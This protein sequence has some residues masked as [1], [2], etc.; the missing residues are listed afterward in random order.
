MTRSSW[1]TMLMLV[2]AGCGGT[3][4]SFKE[5]QGTIEVS[6]GLSDL[7]TLVIG[8]TVD[9]EIQVDNVEGADVNVLRVDVSNLDG[10]FFEVIQGEATVPQEGSATLTLRYTPLEAGY[11]YAVATVISDAVDPSIEVELRGIGA[12]AAPVLWPLAVDFGPVAVG[13]SSRRT[14]SISNDGDAPFSVTSA[15]IVDAQFTLD[16]ALPV[17][18]EAG[19]IAVLDVLFTPSTDAAAMTSMQL[20]LDVPGVLPAVTLVGN[21][22]ENGDPTAYDVDTDGFTTCGGDCD[23]SDPGVHPGAL[24][25]ADAADQDCD[26]AVD[27]G[28]SASDDDGDG[29]TEDDGDCNDDD[30]TVAPGAVEVPG[31]G[32]D[33]DCDGVVD[34]GSTDGDGDGVSVLGGDCDDADISVFPGAPELVDGKD[35]DCDGRTDEG[36]DAFDDDGDGYS[37]ATGDCDDSFASSFPGAPELADYRDN[38]CDTTVDEGTVLYDDDRDGFTENGG[39]CD[40][41][42]PLINPGAIESVGDGFDNDCDGTAL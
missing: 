38:D 36:T 24:E 27:E 26:G 15:G 25:T 32:V 6:P 42:N 41:A 14:V 16:T 34:S 28:T 35:N 23:D 39:D 3:D 10:D 29:F 7:G 12:E 33:D 9:F 11:H 37:E 18:V 19:D 8:D 17:L 21:D 2:A 30:R 1:L 22:C 5:A 4:V 13:G 40:D 20:D 31:N